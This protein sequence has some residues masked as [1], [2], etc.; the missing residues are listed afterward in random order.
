MKKIIKTVLVALMVSSL[1]GCLSPEEKAYKEATKLIESGEYQDA[2]KAFKQLGEYKDSQ[3]MVKKAS[4]LYAWSLLEN[5]EYDSAIFEFGQL[6]D[7]EDSATMLLESYYQSGV[8]AIKDIRFADEK[9]LGY[10][11]TDELILDAKWKY[12]NSHQ[13]NLKDPYLTRYMDDL[14]EAGNEKAIALRDELKVVTINIFEGGLKNAETGEPLYDF[15]YVAKSVYTKKIDSLTYVI[16]F[17]SGGQNSGEVNDITVNDRFNIGEQYDP[18]TGATYYMVP[19]GLSIVFYD[20][21]GNVVS[22]LY[23]ENGVE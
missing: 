8:F 4:Y 17:P 13:N 1:F 7:Y 23:Y 9:C 3:E 19:K 22:D 21:D 14:C 2:V 11:D 16:T 6:G 10:K 20:S 5:G 12:V 15:E 18:S